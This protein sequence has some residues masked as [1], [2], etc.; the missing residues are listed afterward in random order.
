MPRPA[1]SSS[2]QPVLDHAVQDNRRAVGDVLRQP[3]LREHFP[4]EVRDGDDHVRGPDVHREH[5]RAAGLKA[6]R[7]GGLPP[8]EL[9]SPAGPTSP[10]TIS[11]SMREATVERARPGG[12]R[13]FRAGPGLAVAQELEEVAGAGQAAA[14]LWGCG[15]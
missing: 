9:A 14:A 10:E 11:A 4:V 15:L 3:S 2:L 6:K 1:S 12:Q 8:L 5:H 7:D 13:Q